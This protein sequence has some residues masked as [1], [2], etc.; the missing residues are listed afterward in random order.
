MEKEDERTLTTNEDNSAPVGLMNTS[1]RLSSEPA[2]VSSGGDDAAGAELLERTSHSIAA[3]RHA[4]AAERDCCRQLEAE[5]ASAKGRTTIT[6]TTFDAILHC[7]EHERSENRQL[8]GT[9]VRQHRTIRKQRRQLRASQHRPSADDDSVSS[10]DFDD[11]DD[12][13]SDFE[14][15]SVPPE[16]CDCT[17][18]NGHRMVPNLFLSFYHSH[19]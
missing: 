9:V 8:H 16:C 3:L 2:S 19:R 18:D 13:M 4:L 12:S 17:A 14:M 5:L 15:V 10:E 11:K 7:V 6:P 1:S